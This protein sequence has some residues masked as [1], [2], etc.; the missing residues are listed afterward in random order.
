M[1]TPNHDGTVNDPIRVTVGGVEACR[2]FITGHPRI[3]V[4]VRTVV[5]LALREYGLIEPAPVR[6]L[7]VV[8][9]AEG[10]SAC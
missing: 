6:H 4:R 9:E 1:S 3:A 10:E 7:H 2:V 5:D 8:P